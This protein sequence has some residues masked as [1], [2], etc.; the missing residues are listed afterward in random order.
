[1]SRLYMT[2][3]DRIN[4]D[5][6]FLECLFVLVSMKAVARVNMF[7]L[8]NMGSVWRKRAFFF[9]LIEAES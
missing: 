4:G 6:R 2:G 9:F 7:P 5:C 3:R 1:M 8:M